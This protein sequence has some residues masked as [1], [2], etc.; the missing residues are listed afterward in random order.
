MAQILI[1][2]GKIFDGTKF[3]LGDV[4]IEDGIIANIS[5]DLS[6]S[7]DF[8]YNAEGK[9]VSAGLVDLHAH[10]LVDKSDK[11]GMQAE[12]CCFPFGVTAAADAGRSR[13]DSAIMSRFFV[14]NVV[15]V[16]A[17][18]QNGNV[19]FS[20]L[21]SALVRFADRAVGV[22][23]YFDSEQT[24]A[25]NAYVVKEIC[26]YAAERNLR[27]MVHCTNCPVE[28]SELLSVLRDGD[29]LTHAFHGSENN[30]SCDDFI[31][32]KS[33][34]ARGVVIDTGFAGHV[35]TD[36][37]V[38]RRATERGIVPDTISTD[39]TRLSAFV[40]GGRYGMTMCMSIARLVGLSEID[41]F[42]AVTSTPAKVLGK[43]DEWGAL[44]VGRCADVS[45]FEFA[46]EG[47]SLTDRAGNN[48][49][50]DVG[51]RCNLTIANGQVVYKY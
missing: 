29:I 35:H 37:S 40:R 17:N 14:K 7:A 20:A 21:D 18:I 48:I 28:M 11:Y 42:R 50:S 15:F 1:K 32:L 9:I 19:D 10:L 34:Q 25:K 23:I 30:V 49:K 24:T 13:G 51:Y 44:A 41:I 38:L 31:S 47:F 22:K 46:N 43:S 3:F 12:M 26:D 6:C 33:A 16:S 2:G 36:F 8:V 4:L 39:I 27:V 5:D 45:V